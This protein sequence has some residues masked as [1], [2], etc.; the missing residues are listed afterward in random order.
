MAKVATEMTTVKKL[1]IRVLK[2]KMAI[3]RK[4]MGMA[5]NIAGTLHIPGNMGGGRKHPKKKKYNVG[6]VSGGV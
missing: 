4:Q 6:T 2:L 5:S 3:L 1:R